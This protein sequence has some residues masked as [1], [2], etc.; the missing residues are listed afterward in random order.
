MF[1]TV[2]QVTAHF[3]GDYIIQS[4]WMAT[5]KTRRWLPAIIHAV[6]YGLPFLFLR[7]SISAMAVLVGTHAVIDRYRL[8]RHVC[9][10][11]NQVA[12]HSHRVSWDH[13]WATGYPETTPPWLSV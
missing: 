4:H 1:V 13:S 6:S 7:P 2:D 11:K 12:P 5:E 10:A 8:A 3:V 9:W